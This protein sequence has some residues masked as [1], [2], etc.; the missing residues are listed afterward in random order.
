VVGIVGNINV[1]LNY[2]YLLN[3][4]KLSNYI[5]LRKDINNSFQHILGEHSQCELYFCKGAKENEQNL[6]NLAQ[7]S[8]VVQEIVQIIGRLT[9]NANSLLMNVDNNICEQFNSIINKHLAGKRINFSQRHSYS[10]RVEAAVISHNTAGQLLRSIHKNAVND[11][12]PGKLLL[13]KNHF[14]CI[15]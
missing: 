8:G 13:F 9:T 6:L 1:I 3:F 4:F 11:I 15:N 10:T 7:Q 2:L 12:S 5:G 14:N